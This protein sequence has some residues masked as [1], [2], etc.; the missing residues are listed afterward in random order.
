MTMYPYSGFVLNSGTRRYGAHAVIKLLYSVL[1]SID[2]KL[3][4]VETD[5][6]TLIRRIL[7]VRH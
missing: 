6:I 2:V 5:P 7:N 4:T 3:F 1:V